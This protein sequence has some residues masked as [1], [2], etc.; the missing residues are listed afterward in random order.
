[1]SKRSKKRK[2]RQQAEKHKKEAAA[3][4][5]MKSDA[6]EQAMRD[7]LAE[8]GE[9]LPEKTSKSFS[10]SLRDVG[11]KIFRD[12]KQD[13]TSFR[14]P[15]PRGADTQFLK[16]SGQGDVELVIGL[17]FGTSC[18]KVVIQDIARQVGYAVPF[19]PDMQSSGTC[20]LPTAVKLDAEQ[21]FSLFGEGKEFRGLKEHV[22]SLAFPAS[23]TIGRGKRK[24]LLPHVYAYLA[25]VFREVRAWLMEEHEDKFA[26]REILWRVNVGL[27]ASRFD[28][29]HM[30][31]LYKSI[32]RRAWYLSTLNSP[33]NAR[34]VTTVRQMN[35][36][37]ANEPGAI[38]SGAVEAFPEVVAAVQGYAKSPQRG[39]GMHLLVDVGATTMDVTCF[40]LHTYA[41]QDTYPI[42]CAA[43]RH[44]GGFELF[45]H[46]ARLVEDQIVTVM[47]DYRDGLDGIT[48]PENPLNLTFALDEEAKEGVDHDFRNQVG[49][50]IGKVISET[51]KNGD[52]RAPEWNSTLPLFLIGGA[53]GI[54]VY[55][56][57][58]SLIDE[59]P[60]WRFRLGKK[61][62]NL[63]GNVE[64]PG[65]SPS[66][67]QR[68]IVAY[69]LSFNKLDVG[70]LIP[71]SG[72]PDP[73]PV[74]GHP[75]DEIPDWSKDAVQ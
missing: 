33:I 38:G 20:L 17:D 41:H 37:P 68:L 4:S 23:D 65:I 1:M 27:P 64:T 50:T 5:P 67:R 40:R 21:N 56:E 69:G 24:D 3:S 19:A 29:R 45:N 43:V 54:D 39:E 75:H 46:R 7:A 34:S 53:S 72:I 59:N 62:L 9:E 28:Q 35:V 47:Q 2:Q 14:P 63:P 18:T 57:A 10:K 6:M 55:R 74:L 42:F 61:I 36:L 25:L 60:A 11:K 15:R 44:L 30:N 73:E 66:I 32:I 70:K 48:R 8:K 49:G 51:R 26:G 71:P 22:M 52:P 13:V 31:E 16:R 12:N 58:L